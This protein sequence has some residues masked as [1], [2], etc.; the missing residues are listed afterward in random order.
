LRDAVFLAEVVKEYSEVCRDKLDENKLSDLVNEIAEYDEGH[1]LIARLAGTLLAKEFKCNIDDARKVVD[2][3]KRKATAFIAGFINSYFKINKNRARVLAEVFAIR[4]PFVDILRPGDPILTPGI[5]EVISGF[6][7]EKAYWLS[8]RHHDLIEHT[9]E[10]LLNRESTERVS[11]VWTRIQI[12]EI[13]DPVEHF[14]NGYGKKFVEELRGYSKCWRRLALITGFALA[15]YVIL[16]GKEDSEVLDDYSK[17]GF[18]NL[19]KSLEEALSS[20][21]IDY[22]LVVD[23][24]IPIFVYALVADYPGYLFSEE[25]DDFWKNLVNRE[26]LIKSIVSDAEKLLEVWSGR[27]GLFRNL[28]ALYALGLAVITSKAIELGRGISEED[29]STILKAAHPGVSISLRSSYVNPILILLVR[30]GFEALQHYTSLL[31]ILSG[32]TMLNKNEVS[33]IFGTLNMIHFN[34]EYLNKFKELVWPL[35]DIVKVYSDLLYKHPQY[36]DLILLSRYPQDFDKIK[37]LPVKIMCDLLNVLR[38]KSPELAT[39]AEAY[40]LIPSLNDRYVEGYVKEYC[41]INDIIAEADAVINN[42]KEMAGEVSKLRENKT[43][44]KWIETKTFDLS[45]EGVRKVISNIEEYFT[46]GLAEY[47]LN[48]DR[49]DEA[50]ELYN[51][52]AEI[53]KSIGDIDNYLFAR[54]LVLRVDVIKAS[55]LNEYTNVAK[56]FKDLL[57]EAL[58]NL[59]F[60]LLYLESKSYRLSEYLVYLASIGMHGDVEG[61]LNEYAYLLSYDKEVLVL[62]KLMLKI[63]GYTKTGISS[64]EIVDAYSDS[65]YS[66]FLPALKLALGIKADHDELAVKGIEVAI[67]FKDWVRHRQSEVYERVKDLDAKLLVQLLAPKNSEARLAFMLYSLANGDTDL[68]KG[69]ALLGSIGVSKLLSRLFKEAHDSCCNTGDDKFKLALLKLFYYHI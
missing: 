33:F 28:E 35:V 51:K 53:A 46:S 42:L 41:S 52:V 44:M 65:I 26:D 10:N 22:Y 19:K 30:L 45:E 62:T 49:L 5:V 3:S 64:R 36:V 14:I 40:V 25:F 54:S 27:K 69:H 39:I 15:G 47:K 2:E 67:R 58:E 34:P 24:K 57:N 50:K 18:D 29:A 23:N 7:D 1:A 6:E 32:R 31:S 66:Q 37:D 68:A 8:I 55:N 43:F 60:P 56:G 63:L 20:G 48:V 16:P 61:L 11:E 4:E 21:V 17:K 12:P 38:G 9:I 59:E 13:T